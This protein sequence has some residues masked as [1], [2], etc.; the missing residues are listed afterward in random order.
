VS[1]VLFGD[2]APTGTLPFSWPAAIEDVPINAG[3]PDYAPLY[4]FG[5]GLGW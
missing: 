3:D 5:A 1:D 2:V 4:A